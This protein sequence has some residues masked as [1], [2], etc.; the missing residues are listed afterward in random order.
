MTARI[1]G[2]NLTDVLYGVSRDALIAISPEGKILFWN[3]GAELIFGY[4]S[5]EAIGRCLSDLT[6]PPDRLDEIA[7]AT[8]EALA[9]GITAYE[10]VRRRKDGSSVYVDITGKAVRNDQGDIEFIALSKKDVTKLKVLLGGKLLEARFRGLL[11]SVPDGIVLVN[12]LGLI[13]LVNSQAEHLFLYDK[14]ELLGKSI[15]VL[16]PERYRKGHIQHR[17]NYFLEPRPRAMGAGLELY[18]LRKDG[19]EFPVEISLSPV[20][21]DE[22]TVAMSAIRDITERKKAEAKFRGLLESAPDA[23]VIVNNDGKIVLVNSQ[24][25]KV[26]LYTRE[27]LLGKPVEILVPERFRSD[28]QGHRI[29][30]FA[31]P[32]FRGLRADLE[33]Y[34]RRKD[35]TEFPAEISLSPL[36]TEDGVLIS[37]AIRD[38]TERKL[39]EE[40]RR[41]TLEEANRLKSEF[42][43]N[44]SHE[45][46]TPLN[47]IIG[48]SELMHDGR[49]GPVSEPHKEYLGDILTSS[50]HLLQLINDVLD[51]AKVEAGKIEFQPESVELRKLVEE[52]CDIVRALAAKKR[53]RIETFIDAEVNQVTLDPGKLKQVLYN[54]LSNAIKFTPDGGRITVSVVP[55]DPDRFRLEVKDTGVGIKP[56]DLGKLF[57]EFQQIDASLAK[58]YQGTGLGLALTKKI[59]EAQGGRVGVNSIV[60]TGSSFF[61]VLPRRYAPAGMPDVPAPAIPINRPGAPTLLIIEDDLKEQA[62]LS[63]ALTAAGYNVQGASTGATALALCNNRRYDAITLDLILPDMNGLDFMQRIREK[64]PNRDTPVIAVTVIPD[65]AVAV[66][67]QVHE[68]LT[69]P[70]TEADLIAA[71][72]RTGTVGSSS[73]R[74]LCIDDD[75]N[76]LKLAE[77][78]LLNSGY[79]PVCKKGPVSALKWLNHERPAAIILDLLMP[80]MDGFEF[81][82]EVRRRAD[83]NHIPVIVWTVKDLTREERERLQAL[84]QAVVAK[85]E[86]GT[87]ALLA[88]LQARIRRPPAVKA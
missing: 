19:M 73:Q 37:S 84:V 49:L 2:K 5:Q 27:E 30:Y 23:M 48:F 14:G 78:A 24:A 72:K 86:T 69:K 10:T 75:P 40:L 35:A 57:I 65:D 41:K 55:E 39:Q 36:E 53:L 8:D 46:R 62:W 47:A 22:G 59:V 68:F 52:T 71:V 85:G 51:L 32:R 1:S 12:S 18:G 87:A 54:Y 31:Q 13:V 20:E 76:S 38:I 26:F 58:P 81:M 83:T 33:L 16:L 43:A 88:E 82:E 44:M 7:Q 80:D 63:Q 56:E 77:T 66:H 79:S 61:A 34:G 17:T 6:V 29:N 21:T 15:E 50:K 4:T 3:P 64:G 60:G 70:V 11:E 25:E 42:L 28:H 67:Y 74:I 45:L 9:T